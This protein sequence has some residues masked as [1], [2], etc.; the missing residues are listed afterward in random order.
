MFLPHSQLILPVFALINAAFD[1]TAGTPQ[2][3]IDGWNA[4]SFYWPVAM[5][6]AAVAILFATST[7]NAGVEA[8]IT[9]ILFVVAVP[10]ALDGSTLLST[11]YH[12]LAIP[13][14]IG[15]L[16]LWPRFAHRPGFAYHLGLGLYAAACVLSKPTFGAFAVPFF[17][18]S[19]LDAA[20]HRDARQ[21][22][23]V[24][25][26]GI[27]ALLVYLA[28]IVAFYRHGLHGLVE[29]YDYSKL[30]VTSQYHWYDGAKGLSVLH[31]YLN[32][33]TREMGHLPTA[34]IAIA[35]AGACSSP[36]RASLLTGVTAGIAAALFCLYARSQLH[37]HAEFLAFLFATAVGAL[38]S[39]GAIARASQGIEPWL[40]RQGLNAAAIALALAYLTTIYP[41]T[42]RDTKF[43]VEIEPLVAPTTSAILESPG[44]I[45]I[46]IH[47]DIFFGPIDAWCRAGGNIFDYRRSPFFDALFP[48]VACALNHQPPDNNYSGFTSV[49]FMRSAAAGLSDT[50]A[51]LLR[52]F[53]SL[54]SRASGCRTI[55]AL[56]DRS[57]IV[58]CNLT[59]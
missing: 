22:G 10:M 24:A 36:R 50:H 15:G 38:R 2:Q 54:M 49:I 4:V 47:P 57:A 35:L 55:A 18:M 7:K 31:W 39:S 20:R 46:T 14:A 5:T 17:A 52:S 34:L 40:G 41:L 9:G 13:L 8:A 37:G 48:G 43:A 28:S 29:H 16:L 6:T 25:I 42:P 44:A 12:S 30:Y 32:Y 23:L 1:L 3:I 27:T 11:S 58:R 26:A 33:V 21:A 56:P 19:L 51:A 53:P 45:A 59:P